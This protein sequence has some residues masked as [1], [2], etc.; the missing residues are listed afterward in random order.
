MNRVRRAFSAAVSVGQT[1]VGAVASFTMRFA[2][3]A[4]WGFNTLLGRTDVDY[5]KA[6]GD[7]SRNAIVVSV[8]GWI[9]RNFPDA[10][11]RVTQI[12]GGKVEVIRRTQFGPGAMLGLL[13]RPNAWFSG[14]LMWTAT[15]VDLFTTG[16]GYWVK[17]RNDSGRVVELWWIPSWMMRPGW[18]PD[19][20]TFIGWYEYLVDGVRYLI[21]PQDVVH[22]RLGLDPLNPRLG[23][24]KLAS[25]FR[26]I[27]T[28]DEAANFTAALLSNL[29]VPGVV[30]SPSNT[31]NQLGFKG[32]PDTIKTK[33]ME[34]F[35]GDRRGE[36]LVLTSPTDVKV[37]SFSPTEMN[38]RELRKIPEE[39]I[40]SVLGISAVV[41]GLGA[42]LDR[43]TFTNFGEARAA[44]YEEAV[45]PLQRLIAAEL[46][47]QLLDE[48][49]D[50][51]SGDYDVDFDLAKVRALS[52]GRDNAWKLLDGSATKGL[53]TRADFKRGVG[54]EPDPSGL[55]DVY[56]YPNNYVVVPV[57][58]S[59]PPTGV[60]L[61]GPT[62]QPLP[63]G[64]APYEPPAGATNGNGHHELEGAAA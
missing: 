27:F 43:S 33:F 6:I 55:D 9:A 23:L 62:G 54:L 46:E 2:A 16:N 18:P 52:E 20:S 22:F 44:A 3:R 40:T 17:M 56:V 45:I 37:L 32:D 8:V 19:G 26:E 12:E 59:T 42:G 48:F 13:E 15:I 60:P 49:V 1:V 58:G 51:A 57:G 30:I 63:P 41:V 21:R 14:V 47:V 64:M 61:L 11:V 38:L 31:T 28:D 5:A 24:S 7:P 25:L 36:P 53:L 4:T 39:R 50:L 35:G 29:G 34:R 10:P